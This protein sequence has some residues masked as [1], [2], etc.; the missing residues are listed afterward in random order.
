MILVASFHALKIVLL[1]FF[2]CISMRTAVVD[3]ESK[4]A[5]TTKCRPLLNHRKFQVK[6]SLSIVFI[7]DFQFFSC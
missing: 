7:L 6:H 2:F 5:D 1:F 4:Q 3:P